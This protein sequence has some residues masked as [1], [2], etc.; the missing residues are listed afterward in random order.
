MPQTNRHFIFFDDFRDGE[1]TWH[2][3]SESGGKVGDFA[4]LRAAAVSTGAPGM[5]RI[6]RTTVWSDLTEISQ[7]QQSKSLP[8]AV[9]TVA[10]AGSPSLPP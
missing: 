8:A 4:G 10:H 6:S 9:V 1:I 7:G 2:D 5:T 3:Q